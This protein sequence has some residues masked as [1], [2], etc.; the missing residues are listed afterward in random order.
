MVY[1]SIICIAIDVFGVL[2]Q[3]TCIYILCACHL[4]ATCYVDKI[5]MHSKIILTSILCEIIY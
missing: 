2:I 5:T 1:F 4:I 3:Y